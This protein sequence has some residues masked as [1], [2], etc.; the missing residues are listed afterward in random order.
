MCIDIN[1]NLVW[2]DGGSSRVRKMNLTTGII[3]SV[4]GNTGTPTAVIGSQLPGDGGPAILARLN[5]PEDVACGP[6]GTLYIADTGNHRIRKIDPRTGIITTI[7]G[8]TT[9]TTTQ[10]TSTGTQSGAQP[11]VSN[12][13]TSAAFSGDGQL[14]TSAQLNSPSGIKL[15]GLGNLMSAGLN[16]SPVNRKNRNGRGVIERGNGVACAFSLVSR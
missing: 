4:A 16:L 14:G 12:T 10:T 3:L 7:V 5:A 1:N 15:D 13:L 11:V 8:N 6:D 9:Y 2:A